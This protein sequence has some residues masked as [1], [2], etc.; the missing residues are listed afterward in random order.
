MDLV[1][2]SGLEMGEVLRLYEE[3]QGGMER[4]EEKQG[5]DR[6]RERGSCKVECW[7]YSEV[8]ILSRRRRKMID[9]SLIGTGGVFSL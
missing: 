3:D 2:D 5:S 4:Q 7:G 6:G 9:S 8:C 1:A